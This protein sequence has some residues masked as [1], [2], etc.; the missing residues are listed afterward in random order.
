MKRAEPGLGGDGERGEKRLRI[1]GGD[2]G[3]PGFAPR[4]CPSSVPH[5]AA[6]PAPAR[7]HKCPRRSGPLR[8]RGFGGSRSTARCRARGQ[9]GRPRLLYRG[10]GAA[11]PRPGALPWRGRVQQQQQ[12]SGWRGAAGRRRARRS[13]A[14][15]ARAAGWPPA[16]AVHERRLRH[17]PRLHGSGWQQL[18]GVWG[19]GRPQGDGEAAAR[20]RGGGGAPRGCRPT[21]RLTGPCTS[22]GWAHALGV[23]VG[24]GVGV[25]E[26][27]VLPEAA[28]HAGPGDG[29]GS[30]SRVSVWQ[31]GQEVS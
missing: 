15:A 14:C 5:R 20:A 6:G 16:P 3:G 8:R 4:F 28:S 21:T 13:R 22:P 30:A 9:T 29:Q 24:V 10:P 2:G 19:R 12:Q 25:G 11:P 26:V 23:G 7:V 17:A 1:D 27:H 18:V 31:G